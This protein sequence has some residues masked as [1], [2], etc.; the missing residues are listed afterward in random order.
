M[1]LQ[2]KHIFHES[3]DEYAQ[4][5]IKF[6]SG[7][8]ENADWTECITLVPKMRN[9]KRYIAKVKLDITNQKFKSFSS[10]DYVVNLKEIVT[11]ETESTVSTQKYTY[12]VKHHMIEEDFVRFDYFP[13]LQYPH[14]HINANEEKWGNHL[15]YPEKTNLNLKL[16]DS[17]KALNIFEKFQHHPHHH[18]LD[19]DKNDMYKDILQ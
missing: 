4:A 10:S 15:T 11:A 9:G 8:M 5:R 2:N 13:Y 16:L 14:Y 6:I 7:R 1:I 12:E 19:I 3:I 18:I 17:L